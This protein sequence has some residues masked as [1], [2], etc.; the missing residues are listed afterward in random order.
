MWPI[1]PRSFSDKG[2]AE[3]RRPMT[4]S[5]SRQAFRLRVLQEVTRSG[6]VT[7]TCE[8]Y[9]ISRTLFYRLRGRFQ[10]YGP[11]GRSLRKGMEAATVSTWLC[12]SLRRCSSLAGEPSLSIDQG[13]SGGHVILDHRLDRGRQHR[14]DPARGSGETDSNVWTY[15]LEANTPGY[16]RVSRR[17]NARDGCIRR[18]STTGNSR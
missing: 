11:A 4:L 16:D 1:L 15:F 7:A 3:G 18:A 5:D 9:G 8:R 2:N 10:R 17:A 12:R 13:L 6:N 14:L